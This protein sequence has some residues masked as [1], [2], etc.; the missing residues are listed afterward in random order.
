VSSTLDFSSAVATLH[1][2]DIACS[3]FCRVVADH[4]QIDVRYC[5][6]MASAPPSNRPVVA[7]AI[8]AAVAIP[9]ALVVIYAEPVSDW[10]AE[11]LPAKAVPLPAAFFGVG[12]ALLTWISLSN[13]RQARASTGWPTT[14]GRIIR[15]EVVKEMLYPGT[16]RRGTKVPVFTPAVEFEYSVRGQ[17]YRSDRMQFGAIVKAAEDEAH[18]RLAPY[19]VGRQLAVRYDPLHPESAVLDSRVAYPIRTIVITVIFAVLALHFGGVF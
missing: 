5:A 3:P 9:L 7:A 4:E 15:S 8:L 2:Y 18:A 14:V 19:P 11:F 12:A 13:W 10:L 17:T 16:A 6:A 1:I